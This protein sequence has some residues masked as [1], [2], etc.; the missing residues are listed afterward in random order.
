MDRTYI[1]RSRLTEAAPLLVISALIVL[2]AAMMIS[3]ENRR[4]RKNLIKKISRSWGRMPDTVMSAEEFGSIPH[5]FQSELFDPDAYWVDDITWN[6]CDMDRI[7]KALAATMTSPGDSVLY[8]WLRKPS[9]DQQELNDRDQLI[10]F[11][12]S[13]EETRKKLL[14]VLAETGRMKGMSSYD[15]LAALRDAQKIGSAKFIVPGIF[16]LAGIILLFVN[17]LIGLGI[18][19]PT[20]AVNIILYLR[21]RETTKTQIRAFSCILKM[22]R[23]AEK[24]CAMKVPEFGA[25]CAELEDAVRKLA[26]FKKGA[27]L[28]T[29]SLT[30]GTGLSDMLLEY[31]KLFFHADLIKFDQM[32]D[33]VSGNEDACL[34]L[35]RGIGTLDAAC[36][37]A[38]FREY[39]PVSC[40]PEFTENDDPESGRE[41]VIEAEGM[42]H[43]L[44]PD[45]V[46]NSFAASGGNLITGSNASGKS[47]FLKSTAIAQILAQSIMTVP[48][49][50]WRS[51]FL[52]VYSSMALTDDLVKGESY[53]I[54]EIRSLKRIMDAAAD[55][56]GIP[57]LGIVDEVLRG[58][59]TI[60][61]ISASSQILNKIAGDQR[62]IFAA[63]HDIELTYILDGIYRNLHFEEEV[64]GKDVVFNYKLM[65][66]RA[67]S[68][69][70]ITLLSVAGYDEDVV[71][72]ARAQ[73]ERFEE[74]GEWSLL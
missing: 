55:G 9:F 15:G 34:A 74:T 22:I 26:T 54:V 56:S 65:P 69:N 16:M 29:S 14:Y 60:E 37:A 17:P 70:A 7:F 11:L 30:K 6:D 35:L 27:F 31:M 13:D 50:S 12:G 47:T 61:R 5:Y 46:P 41:V 42:V 19:L 4:Q 43:P 72:G 23:C 49:E 68:R 2:A 36:A 71:T 18:I 48:A 3:Q 66:G 62:I 58:T 39:L 64:R 33:A 32:L 53:F 21:S 51:P 57:V 44:L 59:N 73:A 28:V 25:V 24:I 10:G 38:S 1:R 67:H 8:A 63:T 45:A 20:M 52:R 40:R